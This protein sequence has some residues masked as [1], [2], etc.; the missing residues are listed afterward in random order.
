MSSPPRSPVFFHQPDVRG[1]HFSSV[2][3]NQTN[4]F[5]N[6]LFRHKDLDELL[7]PVDD[8][9]Y[10]RSGP[11]AKCLRGTREKVIG[12]IRQ[13]IRTGDRPICWLIGPAGSGKSAISQTVAEHYAAKD[14]LL[15]SFFFLRGAGERSDIA[16]VIHTLAYQLSISIPS[17]KSSIQNII[18][19]DRTILSQSLRYQFKKLIIEPILAA[20]NTIFARF[21]RTKPA[22][23]VIDALDECNDKDSMAEFIE[24]V[25]DAFHEYR[26]LPFRIFVT[27]RVEE[28]IRKKIEAPIACSAIHH[29]SLLDFDAHLDIHKFFQ[30]YFSTIYDENL[31][32][33]QSIPLPWPSESDLDALTRKCNGLFIF[34]TTLINFI[35]NQKGLPPHKLWRALTAEV[36]LDTLHMQVL[37]DAPLDHNFQRVLGTIILLSSPLS[38]RSL[39]H[40]LQLQA[41]DIVQALLGTQSILMIPGDDSQPIRLF[42]TSLRDLLTSQSRSHEFFIDPSPRHFAIAIDCLTIIGIPL[43]KGIIYCGAQKYACLNWCYHFYQSLIHGGDNIHNSQFEISLMKPLKVFRSQPLSIWVN[44]L[45]S[46]G[47]KQTLDVLDSVL[48]ILKVSFLLPL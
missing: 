32:V 6:Q 40:L 29:L 27:S 24:V 43:K 41:V 33:M 23:I 37:Q 26:Q 7:A 36:G 17:T 46:E 35:N 34:A 8:A 4:H 1:G 22:V 18:Q 42:H 28:H 13:C 15:G 11:V 47:Y 30:S 9:A 10:S 21:A 5:S 20:R 16:R 38:I 14:R 39:A 3:G 19:S 12:E 44:T 48:S 25:I 2:S 45:V 31:R